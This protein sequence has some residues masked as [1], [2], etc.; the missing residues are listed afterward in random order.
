MEGKRDWL[1]INIGW[2]WEGAEKGKRTWFRQDWSAVEGGESGD[3]KI[4]NVKM[5]FVS[6]HGNMLQKVFQKEQ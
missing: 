2:R 1:I 3:L 4:E 5:C 6:Q